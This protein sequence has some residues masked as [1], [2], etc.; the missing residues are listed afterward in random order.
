MQAKYTVALALAAGFA[1][2]D[3]FRHSFSKAS[4]VFL[5]RSMQD[6]QRFEMVAIPRLPGGC[7][8]AFLT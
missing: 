6:V 1:R 8:I 7:E 3:R 5:A 2:S 4:L